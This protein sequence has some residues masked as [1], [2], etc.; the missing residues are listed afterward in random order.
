MRR[1]NYDDAVSYWNELL[2]LISDTG[3]LAQIHT[4][5]A[6]CFVQLE[7]WSD[8]IYAIDCAIEKYKSLP[9]SNQKAKKML[10]KLK[11]MRTEVEGVHEMKSELSS[12]KSKS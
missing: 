5:L 6:T 12:K 8:A 1:E 9:R 3:K 10:I 2:S 7:K 11:E 4:N